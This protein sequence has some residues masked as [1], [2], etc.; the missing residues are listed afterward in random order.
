[1]MSDREL[2]IKS[3]NILI[4]WC[5]LELKEKKNI[6][7]LLPQELHLDLIELTYSKILSLNLKVFKLIFFYL[8]NS[9][10]ETLNA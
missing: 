1:M 8:D 4:Y 5:S 6:C 7:L 9:K 2:S 10:P 3:H